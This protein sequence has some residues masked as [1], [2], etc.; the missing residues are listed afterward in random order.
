[1]N[2]QSSDLM[3]SFFFLLF[4]IAKISVCLV[5]VLRLIPVSPSGHGLQSRGSSSTMSRRKMTL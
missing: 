5:T 1:M 3:V 4:F 2:E